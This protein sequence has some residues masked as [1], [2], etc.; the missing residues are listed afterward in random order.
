M[1]LSWMI[2]N[3]VFIITVPMI[4]DIRFRYDEIELRKCGCYAVKILPTTF[5]LKDMITG[6]RFDPIRKLSWLIIIPLEQ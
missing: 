6:Y 2:L 5:A 3:C 4:L 1:G